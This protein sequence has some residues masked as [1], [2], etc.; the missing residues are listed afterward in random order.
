M[1]SLALECTAPSHCLGIAWKLKVHNS[2][3]FC[4]S[5]IMIILHCPNTLNSKLFVLE[6]CVSL[7]SPSPYYDYES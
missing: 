3:D 4:N 1:V 2:G 6:G 7:R 5:I